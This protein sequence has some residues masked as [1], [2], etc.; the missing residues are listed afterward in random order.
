MVFSDD[1]CNLCLTP[2][3]WELINNSIPALMKWAMSTNLKGK[4]SFEEK[5]ADRC[6]S[7]S[8]HD[9]L[10][11][12]IRKEATAS[13]LA[14]F[15]TLENLNGLVKKKFFD[16]YIRSQ[17]NFIIIIWSQKSSIRLKILIYRENKI[18]ICQKLEEIKFNLSDGDLTFFKVLINKFISKIGKKSP[19]I[20][21][22]WVCHYLTSSLG[23]GN[24]LAVDAPSR[25]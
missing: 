13:P 2:R 22:G 18:F 8:I 23:G 15:E 25:N 7:T 6:S 19:N 11:L 9:T 17:H 12:G 16:S 1:Q 4:G 24:T 10:S 20:M 21:I 3:A 5:Y 14:K